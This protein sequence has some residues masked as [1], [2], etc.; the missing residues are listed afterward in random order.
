MLQPVTAVIFVACGRHYDSSC[1]CEASTTSVSGRSSEMTA[2]EQRAASSS[3][4]PELQEQSQVRV[5][6]G[7]GPDPDPFLLLL[8]HALEGELVLLDK[9][10][11]A[12]NLCG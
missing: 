3:R 4:S 9:R 10:G 8:R 11:R 12:V 2:G 1:V 7:S 6:S 5:G